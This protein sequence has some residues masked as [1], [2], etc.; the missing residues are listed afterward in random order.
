MEL[1]SSDLDSYFVHGHRNLDAYLDNEDSYGVFFSTSSQL[2][3]TVESTL[4]LLNLQR[5]YFIDD[6]TRIF[7]VYMIAR[8][9]GREQLFYSFVSVSFHIDVDGLIRVEFDVT[10]VPMIQYYYGIDGYSWRAREV[11]IFEL[12]LVFL[13]ALFTLRELKQLLVKRIVPLILK[14]KQNLQSM[15]VHSEV[16]QS[17][18]SG[19]VELRSKSKVFDFE[20]GEGEN[21]NQQEAGTVLSSKHMV[22][23]GDVAAA[24]VSRKGGSAVEPELVS[25]SGSAVEHEVVSTKNFH[26][27]IDEFGDALEDVLDDYV[28]D[29]DGLLDIL[30]WMTII[31][32]L[33]AIIYR[34]QYVEKARDLH[35][36]IK[37]LESDGDAF[38]DYLET[39]I[40]D[41][42]ELGRI[43]S[44][45]N[46][47]SI[48]A[49]CVGIMQFFRYLSFD[50]KLGI[51]TE[52]IFVVSF[53]LLP[54]LF[55][56]ITIVLAYG[57]LGTKIYGAQMRGML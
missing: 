45:S 8:N 51:V 16:S 28:P 32:I 24:A 6:N 17:E 13:F 38:D 10:Y 33:I 5:N 2:T 19:D 49:V 23:F 39:L 1:G 44:A 48:V 25:K 11:F 50:R 56:F 43:A 30:D 12:M 47:I 9:L 31:I 29:A 40:G 52:T 54:V 34:F 4:G 14:W 20:S 7:K 15:Q 46:M 55:I 3:W 22:S 53:D 27:K 36:L 41:F 57:V 37:S 26:E 42:S 35:V 18:S 21:L